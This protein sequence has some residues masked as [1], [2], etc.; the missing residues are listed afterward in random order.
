VCGSLL[1]ENGTY[2]V[3]AGEFGA[4][5]G[6]TVRSTLGVLAITGS[7]V[8]ATGRAAAGI[9]AGWGSMS[10]AGRGWRVSRS[11]GAT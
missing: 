4:A 10:G 8:T 6:S 9:G 11:A 7:D 2:D 1:I 3:T 5:I